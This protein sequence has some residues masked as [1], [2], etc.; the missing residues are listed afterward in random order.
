MSKLFTRK[1]FG[2][3]FYYLHTLLINLFVRDILFIF[4]HGNVFIFLL[5]FMF[6]RIKVFLISF[7][8][9]ILLIK[10][11][12]LTYSRFFIYNHKNS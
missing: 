10:F 2:L 11:L 5:I 9:G 7:L 3:F 4:T 8:F 6:F 12:L 1:M